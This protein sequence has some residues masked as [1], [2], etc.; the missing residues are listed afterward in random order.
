ML[1]PSGPKLALH[2]HK[3]Q[4]AS[5]IDLVVRHSFSFSFFSLGLFSNGQL[6][7]PFSPVAQHNIPPRHTHTHA[8]ARP[9]WYALL[10]A[11]ARRMLTGA[12]VALAINLTLW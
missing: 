12:C 2:G 7:P 6:L 4:Y 3:N 8:R 5:V 11:H 9:A 1:G 10:G